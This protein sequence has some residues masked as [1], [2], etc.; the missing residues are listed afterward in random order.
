MIN[1]SDFE[2]KISPN[3]WKHIRKNTYVEWEVFPNNKSEFLRGV[4]DKIVNGTY[5][6]SPPREYVV[7]NKHNAVARIVPSLTLEDYCVY[8]YCIVSLEE[9]LAKDRIDGTFGGFRLGGKLRDKEDTEFNEYEEIPFSTSPFTYNP[10]A[11]VTAWR[12]FQKKAYIYSL[13]DGY[14]HF[15][16]FDIAN[17]YNTI[18]LTILERK[19]RLACPRGTSEI[20]DLL[21]F[22]LKYWNK[23]FLKYSEQTVSIPQ[24]EVGDCSRILANFYLQDYDKKI[25]TLSDKYDC[26]YLRYAD[27]MVLISSNKQSAEGIM[28]EA[29]KELFKIGLNINSSKVNRFSTKEDWNYYW[30]FDIFDLLGDKYNTRDISKAIEKL[31]H[32]D[33]TKCRA[34]SVILRILNCDLG[35]VQLDLK[36]KFISEVVN[37]EYLLNASSRIILRIYNLLDKG[38]QPRFLNKLYKLSKVAIFNSYHYNLLKAKQNGLPINFD[39]DLRKRIKELSL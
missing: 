32:L 38:M 1:F 13:E 28:F 29:S 7:S 24:D 10:L 37:D 26:K 12:D 27:D 2:K 30:C 21:I 3:F 31:I 25:K 33:K 34:D 39:N 5:T 22:F 11:W 15:L 14:N 9:Y 35:L 16:K 23:K 19:I 6:P 18:N 8:F 4:F 36:I 17:F 20:I